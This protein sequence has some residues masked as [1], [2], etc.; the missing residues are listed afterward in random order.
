MLNTVTPALTYLVRSNTDVSSLLSGTSIK[1]TISYVTD[2]VTKPAL[3]TYQVFSSAY[4]VYAKNS[5]LIGDDFKM[6]DKARQL[7][8]K[9]VNSLAS[10]M[11]IGSPMA[12][13]YLLDNPDH[14]TDHSFVPFWWRSYVHQARHVQDIHAINDSEH[15]ERVVIGRENGRYVGK[16]IVDDYVYR[17]LCYEEVSLIEWIQCSVKRK[18]RSK[19]RKAFEHA[20]AVGQ[21]TPE[22][23]KSKYVPFEKEHPLFT[24]HEVY[25]DFSRM[26]NVVPNFLGG[27]LP[28]RDQGDREFYC[29]TM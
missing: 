13:L 3:K 23:G 26:K 12:C 8:M 1:S 10:K 15:V 4:D 9:I 27:S 20:I 25:C 17:P 2:Y 21:D 16:S 28:R 5:Q 24:S 29:S 19:V 18:M 6:G 11:E 22:S 7:I 14:Y